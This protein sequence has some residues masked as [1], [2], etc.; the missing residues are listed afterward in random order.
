[1]ASRET[2]ARSLKSWAANTGRTIS[3]DLPFE[4]F[5]AFEA[6]SDEDFERAQRQLL[7]STEDRYLPTQGQIWKVLRTQPAAT[8][9]AA[10]KL[11]KERVTTLGRKYLPKLIEL[12]RR[13]ATQDATPVPNKINQRRRG[14]HALDL[15]Q[16][17]LR[18]HR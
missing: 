6:V 16:C 2:I 13:N 10:Q 3:N 11:D 7:F 17:R 18:F 5:N 12:A 15:I 4:W 8:S 14:R 1:M 9:P